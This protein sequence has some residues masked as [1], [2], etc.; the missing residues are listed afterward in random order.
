MCISVFLTKV[1]HHKEKPA[2]IF[3][4]QVYDY[5]WLC[6]REDFYTAQ[7]TCDG[8]Q[9]G[10]VVFLIADYSPLSLSLFLALMR[11]SVIIVPI[12]YK[13]YEK[14]DD[15]L[16][17]IN[18]D[19]I[20]EV[21]PN[22]EVNL[23]KCNSSAEHSE[24]IRELQIRK[25]AGLIIFSSGSTGKCKA[26][27]HDLAL[28]LQGV[29]PSR[30][31]LKVLSFLLFDH[32]G[33]INSTLNSLISGNCIVVPKTRTPMD[34]AESI[35]RNKV[36][37]LITSP[38]FLNLMLISGV[39]E[40]TNMNCLKQINYG[41]EVMPS[42]LL[43]RL[44]QH[45]PKTKFI[46]AYG[47]SELG[48]IRTKTNNHESSLITITDQNITYRIRNNKLEIKSNTSMLGYLNAPKPFTEDGWFMTGD[49]VEVVGDSL[50]ILGRDSDLINVGGEKVFPVEIENVLLQIPE[51]QDAT[52]Y[53]EKN[54]LLGNII[55][56]KIK[57]R[58]GVNQ[59][60]LKELVRKFCLMKMPAFKVPQ[61]FQIVSEI[62]YGER[63]KKIRHKPTN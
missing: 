60:S 2:V 54:A 13:H 24:L 29:N 19:F 18:P 26:I 23:A 30:D 39:F 57:S 34:V 46:Q 10:S 61:K 50:R 37:V 62:S 12:T 9:A 4:Q 32:I 41:S 47:L 17:I 63:Y 22:E 52:V 55:V 1:R 53:G 35:A 48:V 59:S 45:C 33:G 7:L 36:D 27:V 42:V 3:N 40:H 28:L 11:L 58:H 8:V 51:V 56:A 20:I 21:T 25:T 15:Y 6:Q 38:S 31:Q 44:I 49:V 5:K 43:D 16:G 14:K